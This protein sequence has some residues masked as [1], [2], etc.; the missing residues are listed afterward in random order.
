M[1]Y[2]SFLLSIV[3]LSLVVLFPSCNIN[4]QSTDY[5]NPISTATANNST[6]LTFVPPPR[7][8]FPEYCD[9]LVIKYDTDGNQIWEKIYEEAGDS[10]EHPVAVNTDED[11][12]FFITG[13]GLFSDNNNS[14]S[15]YSTLKYDHNGNLINV[16]SNSKLYFESQYLRKPVI[17]LDSSGNVTSRI[18][19]DDDESGFNI[20]K[21]NSSGD[22]LWSKSFPQLEHKFRPDFITGDDSGNTY[23]LCRD[24]S[25]NLPRQY[26]LLKYDEYGD[27]LWY[28]VYSD[29]SVNNIVR[30][31]A[32]NNSIYILGSFINSAEINNIALVKS[33]TS[34]HQLWAVKYTGP[35]EFD[36][37]K[38]MNIDP[39]GNVY[40]ICNSRDT[41]RKTKIAVIKYDRLGNELWEN[42]Y[43]EDEN[44]NGSTRTAAVDN[45][46]N[47]YVAGGSYPS[48][49]SF[50]IKYNRQGNE[51][52]VT[53]TGLDSIAII[54]LVIDNKGNVIV[55]GNALIDSQNISFNTFK[56]GADGS[57]KWKAE[58]SKAYPLD[59]PSL[60]ADVFN[61]V[62]LIAPVSRYEEEKQ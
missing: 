6:D 50:I 7:L 32:D 40:L 35:G 37:A 23:A 53:N 57:I 51:E 3:I 52:W 56:Y 31:M 29:P 55:S 45:W 38:D 19:S 16:A 14:L 12:N 10:G 28:V 20:I 47:A 34:G 59:S 60:I 22:I 61:N 33:D 39:E 24:Y 30:Y 21:Y 11:G 49:G 18:A 8:H 25:Y 58:Y 5:S 15:T 26:L 62:Y 17:F 46:G 9:L 44:K 41:N 54:S 2:T 27:L 13:K 43:P 42:R 1:K 48:T 36:E 4:H